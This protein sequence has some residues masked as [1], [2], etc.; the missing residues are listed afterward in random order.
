MRPMRGTMQT[1]ETKP[2]PGGSVRL[3]V[4]L[5]AGQACIHAS[6]SGM[7]MAAPLLALREGY[8]PLAVGLL[9]ALFAL[10]QIFLS[11]PAGRFADRHGLR[12]PVGLSVIVGASAAGLAAAWPV[13]PVLCLAALMTGGA[14][15][16]ASIALQRHAGRSASGPTELRQVFSWL[17]I[18]PAFSNFLGPVASG[19]LIDHFGFRTAFVALALV[20]LLAWPIVRGA[21]EL[22]PP[23]QPTGDA[24]STAWNLV[25]EPGFR[26]LLIINWL[27]ASCWDVHTFV[28]PV[29]GHERELSAS[30]IGSLLGAFSV[31]AMAVRIVLPMVAGRVTE[32]VVI[33]LAMA[34]SAILFGIYPLMQTALGMGICSFILGVALGT[35]QPMVMSLLHQI[36]PEHQHG[37]A[38]GLRL[39]AINASSVLM[40]LLF[41]AAGAA[42]GVSA[43][44]WAVG[45]MVTPGIRLA[46]R[47][48][49]P[50]SS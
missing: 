32:A 8:S 50:Q 31:A 43:V 45:I 29:I 24:P 44:F 14:T 22:P 20:A 30:T 19:L 41:G 21:G 7:R 12:R 11:L 13:F 47:V 48:K 16:A 34:S 9:L 39:I 1:P 4:R 15:G 33:A 2:D 42:V 23:E 35:I 6:M 3:L 27:M 36:T 49:P 38:L 25:R 10:T 18:G 28:V 40:P 26:R 17:A 5:I 37:E 46:L